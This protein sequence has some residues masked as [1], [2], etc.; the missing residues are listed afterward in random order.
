MDYGKVADILAVLHDDALELSDVGYLPDD[1]WTEFEDT[2]T[3]CAFVS[4][5][6]AELTDL[7][8]FNVDVAWQVLC[9]IRELDPEVMYDSPL[10]FFKAQ[11]EDA[12]VIPIGRGK[13]K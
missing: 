2:L 13:K 5:K 6:W 12:E 11:A 9:Q 8:K 3:L 10:D 1:Y 7:S 4:A